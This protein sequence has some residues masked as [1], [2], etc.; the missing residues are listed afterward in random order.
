M[1]TSILY[2]AFNL[3]GVEFESTEFLGNAI[4]FSVVMTDKLIKKVLK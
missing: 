3:K 4:I 2:H 1:S